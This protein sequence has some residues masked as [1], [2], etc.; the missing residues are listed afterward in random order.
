MVTSA[1][2][3]MAVSTGDGENTGAGTAL[4]LG[5]GGVGRSIGLVEAFA[6]VAGVFSGPGVCFFFALALAVFRGVVSFF[7][8]DFFLADFFDAGVSSGVSVAF[9]AA[10]VSSGVAL[11]FRDALFFFLAGDAA[12]F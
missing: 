5:T 6:A 4:A 7:A 9:D 3:S 10:T 12:R 8:V 2:C 11:G 1:G